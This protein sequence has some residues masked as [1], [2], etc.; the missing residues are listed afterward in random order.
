[1]AV[2]DLGI[3][4][5]HRSRVFSR[6]LDAILERSRLF[7]GLMGRAGLEPASGGLKVDASASRELVGAGDLA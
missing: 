5:S 3:A 7:S 1:M 4:G 2:S 6:T